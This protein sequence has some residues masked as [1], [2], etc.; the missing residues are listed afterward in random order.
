MT[1]YAVQIPHKRDQNTGLWHPKID[2]KTAEAFGHIVELVQPQHVHAALVTAP[3]VNRMKQALKDFSDDDY[4]LP[5][6]DVTLSSM[7]VAVAAGVNRG[8]VKMLRWNQNEKRHDVVNFNLYNA[9]EDE[10]NGY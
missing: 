9:N 3:T 2:V 5:V 1:V 4:I 7:A 6:G 8:K 10:S